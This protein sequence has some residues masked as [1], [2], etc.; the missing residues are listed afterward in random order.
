MDPAMHSRDA[1]GEPGGDALAAPV[2]GGLAGLV[3][4]RR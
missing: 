2:Y 1:I 4:I 3:N